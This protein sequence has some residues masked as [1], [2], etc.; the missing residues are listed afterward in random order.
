MS[1][2][3]AFK[4]LPKMNP[5]ETPRRPSM[6]P[7][8]MFNI[9][10]TIFISIIQGIEFEEFSIPQRV[11][12][13]N[14]SDF[15]P[16]MMALLEGFKNLLL[17]ISPRQFSPKRILQQ[18]SYELFDSPSQSASKDTSCKLFKNIAQGIHYGVIENDNGNHF[19]PTSC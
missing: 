4:L 15:L 13:D 3:Q 18:I 9:T 12:T 6:H 14:D 7:S 10:K 2:F 17:N 16:F 19:I 11:A 8:P 5:F 1:T